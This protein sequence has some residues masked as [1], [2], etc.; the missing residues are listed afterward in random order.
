MR[1]ASGFRTRSKD[2][3]GEDEEICICECQFLLFTLVLV[4][5]SLGGERMDVVAGVP[6]MRVQERHC[7]L[8]SC[9]MPVLIREL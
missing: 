9:R 5:S 1:R 4:S 8:C 3:A 6:V 2:H 7:P